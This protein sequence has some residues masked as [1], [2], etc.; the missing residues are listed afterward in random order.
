VSGKW[1][2]AWGQIA[3]GGTKTDKDLLPLKPGSNKLKLVLDDLQEI[4]ESNEANNEFHITVNVTGSCGSSTLTAPIVAPSESAP[5][6]TKQLQR[7]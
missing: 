6:A 5:P 7:H 2:H 1:S 4:Q 3:V